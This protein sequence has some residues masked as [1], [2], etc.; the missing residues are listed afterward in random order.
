MREHGFLI[1]LALFA[2]FLG[3][4]V[5]FRAQAL[6]IATQQGFTRLPTTV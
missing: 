4:S 6:G 1:P 3:L 2:T 5:A